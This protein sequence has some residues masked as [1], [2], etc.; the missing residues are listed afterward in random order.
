MA[1]VH[2]RAGAPT[3]DSTHELYR[4]EFNSEIRMN[5]MSDVGD[6]CNPFLYI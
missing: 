5:A 1:P 3:Y 4:R 6:K 2:V